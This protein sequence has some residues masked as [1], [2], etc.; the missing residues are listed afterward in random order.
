MQYDPPSDKGKAGKS[1]P[2][3]M[4][5]NVSKLLALLVGILTVPAGAGYVAAARPGEAAGVQPEVRIPVERLGYTV[6]GELPSLYAYALVELYYVDATHLLFVFNRQGLIRR[7][8]SCPLPDAEQRMVR[9]VVLELPTGKVIHQA[10][11]NLYDLNDYLWSLND[12]SF[13]MRRCMQLERVGATLMPKPLIAAAGKIDDV[14]FAPDRSLMSVEEE[15]PP[16]AP[17]AKGKSYTQQPPLRPIS[18]QFIGLQPLRVVARTRV[19]T[20]GDIPLINSG[21]LAPLPGKSARWQYTL[22][23]FTGAPRQVVSVTSYCRPQTVPLASAIFLSMLCPN[24][25][26]LEYDG[27]N[28]QGGHMWRM[29]FDQMHLMP[30]YLLSRDGSLFGIETLHLIR[31]TAGIGSLTKDDVNGQFLDIFNTSTG[32]PMGELQ[33]SPIYTGGRNADFSPDGT[34]VAILR[35]G[36]IEIYR[37]SDLAHR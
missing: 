19:Q 36:A 33:I 31:P 35:N 18:V 8:N 4:Y 24:P 3:C 20:P 17:S 15:P 1:I 9:A 34:R 23:P 25:Q 27:Y 32:K 13:L 16:A 10:D 29:S 14:T 2:K 7:D 30:E 28:L 6:P 11:W 21:I 26:A 5:M 12:G 37:L 22:I